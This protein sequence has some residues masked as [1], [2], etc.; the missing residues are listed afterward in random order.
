MAAP[1]ER[2]RACG[3][4]RIDV[5]I[6]QRRHVV[7]AIR[8]YEVDDVADGFATVI[9]HSALNCGGIL[10]ILENA[11]NVQDVVARCGNVDALVESLRQ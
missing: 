6:R 2:A 11:E 7:R 8:R 4:D 5:G 9:G 10:R 1:W 3:R